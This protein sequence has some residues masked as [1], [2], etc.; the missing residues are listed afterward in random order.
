MNKSTSES[1]IVTLGVDLATNIFQLH[2]VDRGLQVV[3]QRAVMLAR[4]C[5]SLAEYRDACW[6]G[7]VCHVTLCARA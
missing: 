3:V 4:F 1:A 6:H 2:D 5:A 7:G